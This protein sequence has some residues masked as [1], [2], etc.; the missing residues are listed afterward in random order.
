MKEQ[1]KSQGMVFNEEQWK[2]QGMVFNESSSR[3][4]KFAT[5]IHETD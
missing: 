5:A 4:R 1:W 3:S 2:S